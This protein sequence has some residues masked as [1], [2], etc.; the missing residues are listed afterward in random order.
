[1]EHRWSEVEGK[2][3][4]PGFGR[5]NFSFN[6]NQM[7]QRRVFNEEVATTPK[8][9]FV[10]ATRLGSLSP[11]PQSLI[12]RTVPTIRATAMTPTRN[13]RRTLFRTGVAGVCP[14]EIDRWLVS[15]F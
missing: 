6:L 14:P 1:M 9:G 12:I 4:V 8:S 13:Q 3:Y 11:G 7:D 2:V 5:R 10:V 15:M